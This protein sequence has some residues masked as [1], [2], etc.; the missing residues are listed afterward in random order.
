[1]MNMA[2]VPHATKAAGTN[3]SLWLNFRN[4]KWA[5][6]IPTIVVWYTTNAAFAVF[7]KRAVRHPPGNISLV[8][9]SL[10]SLSISLSYFSLSLSRPTV[11]WLRWSC[12]R[13]ASPNRTNCPI[14]WS[15]FASVYCWV[16]VRTIGLGLGFN[17]ER[18]TGFSRCQTWRSTFVLNPEYCF[19]W[20]VSSRGWSP[21]QRWVRIFD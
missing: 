10:I 12:C 11:Q 9:L 13:R 5:K 19:C 14:T 3:S 4:W 6:L 2:F 17:C 7:A 16:I 21:D 1:M 8:Y 20:T 15:F 18:T